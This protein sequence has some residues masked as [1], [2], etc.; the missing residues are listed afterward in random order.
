MEKFARLGFMAVSAAFLSI[1]APSAAS[2]QSWDDM[3]PQ[4]ATPLQP[5]DN[6]RASN[7]ANIYI[8]DILTGVTNTLPISAEEDMPEISDDGSFIAFTSDY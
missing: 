3:A 6:Q 2:A 5:D 7:P 8:Y 4:Q 1:V